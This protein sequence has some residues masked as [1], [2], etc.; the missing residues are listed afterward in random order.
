MSRAR[1]N[2]LKNDRELLLG[3]DAEDAMNRPFGFASASRRI[4]RGTLSR[5]LMRGTVIS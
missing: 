5:S 2:P 3:W 1:Q 4:R